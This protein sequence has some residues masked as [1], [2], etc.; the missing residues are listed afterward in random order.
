MRIAVVYRPNLGTGRITVDQKPSMSWSVMH[1]Q[2]A[3]AAECAAAR[4]AYLNLNML[5]TG[6][7]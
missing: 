2:C 5:Q 1:C 7:S 3:V 4:Q 6:E